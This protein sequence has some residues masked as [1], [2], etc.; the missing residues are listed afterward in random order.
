MAGYDMNPEAQDHLNNMEYTVT[1]TGPAS[2]STSRVVNAHEHRT[3]RLCP[4][5]GLLPRKE[6][7]IHEQ[8]FV[9]HLRHDI[10]SC[11]CGMVFS[12]S[13]LTQ[14]WYDEYYRYRSKYA[15]IGGESIT[16]DPSRHR[17][18]AS[19]IQPFVH[20]DKSI[21]DIG[22]ANGILLE[23]LRDFGYTAAEGF[24]PSAACR[25]KCAE[26]GLTVNVYPRGEYDCIVLSHVLEHIYDIQTE[27]PRIL[28]L[29]KMGGVVYIEVPDARNYNDLS[30]FQDFNVEHINHF[31]LSSL[32]S[33]CG[34]HGLVPLHV[35]IKQFQAGDGSAYNAIFGVFRREPPLTLANYVRV[36][37]DRL[38]EIRVRLEERLSQYETVAVWGIGALTQKL[39]V[40]EPLK[41]KVRLL[42]DRNEVY[43]GKDFGRW[44]VASP[45][46]LASSEGIPADVPIVVGSILNE[47]S[48][49]RSIEALKLPNP[50]VTLS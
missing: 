32:C 35:G 36:S 13:G 4:L 38:E 29:A 26:K 10:Y 3:I 11:P 24:D 1:T 27:F 43:W 22:C 7:K 20:H 6:N 49:L 16:E 8:H 47:K 46:L 18:T 30:P 28:S 23:T 5:C 12:D 50:V 21:L 42:T 25:A 33:L 39:L 19:W 44:K 41:S 48:I 45:D 9:G 40:L 2:T 34:R 17:H 37:A 31:S 15:D 14:F